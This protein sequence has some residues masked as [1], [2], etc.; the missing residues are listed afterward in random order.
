MAERR[1][2][3]V[4]ERGE[5]GDTEATSNA[6]V[7]R[8]CPHLMH[9]R[10]RNFFWTRFIELRMDPE[11]PPSLVDKVNVVAENPLTREFINLWVLILQTENGI[12]DHDEI[13]PEPK[14]CNLDGI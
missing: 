7:G 10:G 13:E 8:A 11:V 12:M 1:Q 2:W 9:L 14:I 4:W 5:C 6:R 3:E